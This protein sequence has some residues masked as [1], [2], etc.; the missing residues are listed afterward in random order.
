LKLLAFIFVRN[1]KPTE[2][3]ASFFLLLKHISMN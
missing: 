3:H 2:I 1:I